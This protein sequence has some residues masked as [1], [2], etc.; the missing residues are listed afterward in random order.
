MGVRLHNLIQSANW[1]EERGFRDVSRDVGPCE[2]TFDREKKFLTIFPFYLLFF[3]QIP[4]GD[5]EFP[6]SEC[7]ESKSFVKGGGFFL[8][9]AV[10]ITL[11]DRFWHK[12]CIGFY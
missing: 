12:G 9:M 3:L 2:A 8:A 11:L 10:S 4:L 5:T 6:F 7:L 1:Q